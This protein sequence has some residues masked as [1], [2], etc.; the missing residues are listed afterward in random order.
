MKCKSFCITKEMAF[1]LKRLLTERK[2]VCICKSDKG[3]IIR[4]YRELKKLHSLKINDQM[5]ICANELKGNFLKKISTKFHLTPFR[6][7]T[8]KTQTTT[9]V[10]KD[11]GKK[12]PT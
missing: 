4:I 3:L 9:N 1:K 12:E 5:K 6:M 11:V 8:T 7:T 2:K 10:C